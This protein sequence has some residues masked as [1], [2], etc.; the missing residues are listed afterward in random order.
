MIVSIAN[1]LFLPSETCW[2]SDL[3]VYYVCWTPNRALLAAWAQM[4]VTVLSSHRGNNKSMWLIGVEVI[5]RLSPPKKKSWIRLYSENIFFVKCGILYTLL[6]CYSLTRA[7]F[8]VSSKSS[9]AGTTIR[10]ASVLTIGIDITHGDW[11]AAFIQICNE[12]KNL[13]SVT[14]LWYF[15]LHCT[16]RLWDLLTALVEGSK[17]FQRS[18]LEFQG[19]IHV[20][21]V[22]K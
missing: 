14:K 15:I 2:Q 16:K 18:H 4:I 21:R 13:A 17:Y 5:Q 19:S 20:D 22:K 10:A 8:P 6:L 7:G 9:F 3:P 12:M 1:C 11:S